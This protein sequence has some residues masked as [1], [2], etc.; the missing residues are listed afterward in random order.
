MP[1]KRIFFLNTYSSPH[2]VLHDLSSRGLER[3]KKKRKMA[4]LA[5]HRKRRRRRKLRRRKPEVPREK[6]IWENDL[7]YFQCGIMVEVLQSRS[8][9]IFFLFFFG[10]QRFMSRDLS[11][12]IVHYRP[13]TK[14]GNM[15]Y[16]KHN[17][18]SYYTKFKFL[19]ESLTIGT[20]V[21]RTVALSSL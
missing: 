11:V 14:L 6:K 5:G 12:W 4:V 2:P 15:F 19:L 21:G 9:V 13:W 10:S 16:H 18:F 7:C 1:V 3:K 8:R 20:M 17:I